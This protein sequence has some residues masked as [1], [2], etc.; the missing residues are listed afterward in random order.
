MQE[1]RSVRWILIVSLVLLFV[2]TWLGPYLFGYYQ[3]RDVLDTIIFYINRIGIL[4]SV[5][6]ITTATLFTTGLGN[7]DLM[8]RVSVYLF[9]I[10]MALFFVSTLRSL[11]TYP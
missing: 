10:S 11:F 6:T 5:A 3:R 2:S 4:F 7:R 1:E 9:I 8:F